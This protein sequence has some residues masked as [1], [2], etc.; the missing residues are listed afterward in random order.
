MVPLRHILQ[1]L[2]VLLLLTHNAIGSVGEIT[3]QSQPAQITRAQAKSTTAVGTTVEMGDE[4]ETLDGV[5]KIVFV[6][7]TKVSLSEYSKLLIDEFVY[8]SSTSTGK[9]NI[10]GKIG[11][12]RYTS[13]AIA[14]HS[15]ENVKIESP[16]ASVAVRGTDFTMTVEPTGRSTFQLL[17]SIDAS[18]NTYVGAIE[19]SN[20]AGTV[21]LNQAYQVTTVDNGTE[22]PSQPVKVDPVSTDTGKSNDN[23][24]SNKDNQEQEVEDTSEENKDTK[25]KTTKLATESKTWFYRDTEQGNVISLKFNSN[26]NATINYS[27]GG[28]P[29]SFNLNNGNSIIFNINQ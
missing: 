28:D 9:L 16:T 17:P 20:A 5:V 4:L 27:M 10:K 22:A 14:K 6:D 19:V 25:T 21:T 11:T 7:D 26:A 8:D 3:E 2:I 29:T 1:L 18:G 24:N 12:L 15:R 23:K 13:G